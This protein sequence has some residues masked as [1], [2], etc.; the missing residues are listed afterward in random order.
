MIITTNMKSDIA[1]T[2]HHEDIH[3]SNWQCVCWLWLVLLVVSMPVS[4]ERIYADQHI[5][6]A[7]TFGPDGRLWRLIP[8]EKSVMVDY[9]TDYGKTFSSPVRVNPVDKP[10]HSWEENPPSISVDRNGSVYVLYFADD[11]QR[12]TSFFSQSVNRL[13][14]SEPVKISS[15]ADSS[16]HYQTEMLVDTSGKIHFMWHD[17]RDRAEYRQQGGGDLS[18]YYV[19]AKAKAGSKLTFPSDKR[20]AR[21]ICSCCRTAMAEDIDGSVVILARFVYPGNVRDHGMFRLS[22]DG[23]PSEPWRVT[24][25]DWEIEGCPTHGPALS[26]SSDG[27]YHMTWF[28]QGNKHS[29]LFY[30]WSDNKGKTFS[31]PLQIGDPNKLPGHPDVLALGKEVALVWKVFD[32]ARTQIAMMRSSDRGVHW[33]AAKVIAESEQKSAHPA[34]ITNGKQIFLSWHSIDKGFQL[35]AI[36]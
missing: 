24:F 25:D 9:S 7:T 16:Y 10:I 29:G 31:E 3:S 6:T 5:Y 21:N 26:I 17:I 32:G 13:D 1:T 15:N 33:S 28:A 36:N 23:T 4:A 11:Q 34:L 8:S 12:S 14:F 22:A 27:R 35:I 30:A 18:I 20:I 2:T 19:S